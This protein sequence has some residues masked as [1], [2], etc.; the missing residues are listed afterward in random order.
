MRGYLHILT[1][2][3]VERIIEESHGTGD[4]GDD[5]LRQQ[6]F[7]PDSS[8]DLKTSQKLSHHLRLRDSPDVVNFNVRLPQEGE[9]GEADALQVLQ[10]DV[11]VEDPGVLPLHSQ[12]HGEGDAGLHVTDLTDVKYDTEGQ[13]QI[14]SI[15]QYF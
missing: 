11:H 2:A 10:A 8:V 13:L 14:S 15:F 12:I 5:N 7:P 9:E 4:S 1:T 3:L 6:D